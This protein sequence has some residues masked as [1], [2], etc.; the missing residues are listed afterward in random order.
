MGRSVG[1][2]ADGTG[3]VSA[4]AAKD[5]GAENADASDRIVDPTG[6][7]AF[8]DQKASAMPDNCC[9]ASSSR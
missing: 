3:S 8:A 1:I 4:S 9:R 5:R 6:D 7:R 2:D